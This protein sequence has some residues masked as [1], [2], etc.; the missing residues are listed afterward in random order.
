MR[1]AKKGA[2]TPNGEL[3]PLLAFGSSCISSVVLYHSTILAMRLGTASLLKDYKPDYSQQKGAVV[4]TT[5]CSYPFSNR[6]VIERFGGVLSCHFCFIAFYVL[7]L[8][9]LTGLPL[10]SS[11]SAT[12]NWKCITWYSIV[13]RTLDLIFVYA[14][15]IYNLCTRNYSQ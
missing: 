15:F 13:Q 2:L 8:S 12:D 10:L 11:F 5:D 1:L 3:F 4:F 9:F 7:Y 6:C 14:N